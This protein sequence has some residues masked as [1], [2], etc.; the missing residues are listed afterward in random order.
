[1]FNLPNQRAASYAAH[2]F[3]RGVIPLL[4]FVMTYA[5]GPIAK[6]PPPLPTASAE[7]FQARAAYKAG[8][9]ESLRVPLQ[10][11]SEEGHFGPEVRLYRAILLSLEE[12]RRALDRLR[13]LRGQVSDD[14]PGLISQLR[15]RVRL[16]QTIAE[17]FSGESCHLTL[18]GLVANKKSD[19]FL[20]AEGDQRRTRDAEAHCAQ[21]RP[22]LAQAQ[23]EPPESKPAAASP[24]PST[25]QGPA[26]VVVALPL[27]LPKYRRLA[28]QL[29]AAAEAYHRLG[30]TSNVKA[31]PTAEQE[32]APQATGEEAEGTPGESEAQT[33]TG[34]E[35]ASVSPFHLRILSVNNSA[36]LRS[37]LEALP[38]SPPLLIAF[39][40]GELTNAFVENAKLNRRLLLLISDNEAALSAPGEI[41][42]LF[43]N[44]ERLAR[45]TALLGG[46]ERG[47]G[48]VA[49]L[50]QGSE[51]LEALLQ[52]AWEGGGG[53][54]EGSCF[55]KLENT[56]EDWQEVAMCL[57]RSAA[58]E[59]LLPL[60]GRKVSLA[61]SHLAAHGVWSMGAAAP[62]QGVRR[63]RLIGW[64]SWY[65]ARVLRNAGR[66][67]EGALL[68]SPVRLESP[69]VSALREAMEPQNREKVSMLSL[70]LVELIHLA[71]QAL[72]AQRELP[73][74][75]LPSIF[76]E[77][78]LAARYLPP[79]DWSQPELLKRF[80]SLEVHEG[81]FRLKPTAAP[82]G[83]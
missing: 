34:A 20:R 38:E 13:T 37:Q 67:L 53:R 60:S 28:E 58:T 10:R 71:N 66:Y 69:E 42:R 39:A 40:P 62:R 35:S 21:Q 47:Q 3:I 18:P 32:Q 55:F 43:L 41:W 46:A 49:L 29:R 82:D 22:T 17:L 76:L 77:Q 30:A 73:T 61:L 75:S 27:E 80:L 31:A 79:L 7:L 6:V 4:L 23:P 63:F 12:P 24:T 54:W 19:W 83:S 44:Q 16:H 70:F 14:M 52:A 68:P 48:A 2:S 56:S 25:P 5:C 74:L 15:Q 72:R 36:E 50:A 65:Q 81:A 33:D 51:R 9:W 78:P 59:L 57:K 11:L 1:M 26:E 64:P 8:D 45:A